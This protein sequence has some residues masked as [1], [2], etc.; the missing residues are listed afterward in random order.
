MR[1][2]EMTRQDVDAV[3]TMLSEFLKEEQEAGAHVQ[4][5]ERT[6]VQLM[7]AV[8]KI[9]DR[10]APGAVLIAEEGESAIGLAAFY[11]QALDLDH[12][13][14]RVARSFVTYV[15]A[16]HRR[17]GVAAELIAT[18]DELAKAADCDAMVTTTRIE[19]AAM[20][21][22]LGRSGY[23]PADVTFEKRLR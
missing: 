15:R 9:W 2:R 22:L 11:I 18:R 16:E 20:R 23:T 21:G 5:G 10:S 8:G 19:N 12:E 1:I 13:W 3:R 6:I 14:R 4:M 7:Q 17:K